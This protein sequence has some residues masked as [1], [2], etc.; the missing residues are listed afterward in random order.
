MIRSL[1]LENW[2]SHYKSDII[3]DSGYNVFVGN[4]GSGKS[5]IIEAIVFALFGTTQSILSKRVSVKDMIMQKPNPMSEAKVVLEF[6]IDS[7]NYKVERILQKE[8]TSTA[9][10]YADNKLIAGPKPSDVNEE[11]EK[12]VGLNIDA[13][14]RANFS[15]QNQIDFFLK[16]PA[17]Q[18]K[19]LFDSIF[20]IQHFDNIA[21]NA[22][23]VANRL[24]AKSEEKEKHTAELQGMLKN[25][26]I[27]ELQKTEK[28]AKELIVREETD[29]EQINKTVEELNKKILELE[30]K[31]KTFEDAENRMRNIEGQI[32]I[33]AKEERI[34]EKDRDVVLQKEK[35]ESKVNK[36]KEIKIEL[37]KLKKL[38]DDKK[39]LLAQKKEKALNFIK[40]IEKNKKFL[41]ETKIDAGLVNQIGNIIKEQEDLLEEIKKLNETYFKY[42]NKADNLKKESKDFDESIKNISELEAKCPV[43]EQ[44]LDAEHK[45]NI[46]NEK[47]ILIAKNQ[48]Q[49]II[50]ECELQ[51][52]RSKIIALEKE[53]KEKEA[54]L[55]KKRELL[56]KQE[57]IE[58]LKSEITDAERYLSTVNHEVH[59]LEKELT[60]NKDVDKA[61]EENE[62]QLQ[63]IKAE[64]DKVAKIEKY[65]SLKENLKILSEIV[66]NLDYN[67]ETH[68][69]VKIKLAESISSQKF[70]KTIIEQNKKIL[71][72][73][74]SNIV[75][76]TQIKDSFEKERKSIVNIHIISD[77]LMI[78][79][80]VAKKTQEEVREK[81]V[82]N[83][84]L[85]FMDLWPK[86]YPYA[87]FEHIKLN[88]VDGDY[89]LEL[90]FDKNYTR[91]L[92]DFIS[93][94]ERSAIAL[95]LRIAM[96]LVMKNKLNLLILDE[97]TH[98][99]DENI[100]LALSDLFNNHLLK[101][102]EQIFVIT[103]DKML[104]NYA[105]NIYVINRNKE[106]DSPSIVEKR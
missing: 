35:I 24:K 2:K 57:Y 86:I 102:T 22:K 68:E 87:D 15:E 104:E 101:F 4:I 56:A 53:G 62:L 16:M 32:E 23:Q 96:S 93:G 37:Q 18:R 33:L 69:S 71:N 50:I 81:I 27:E 49:L 12:I 17:A 85:I 29:F 106:D 51:L 66:Q 11:I 5:S 20:D 91:Q 44:L 40:T 65:L 63:Q 78:F 30:Q 90:Y 92:D 89:K 39:V 46:I 48:E 19:Q 83:I 73:I 36:L 34:S 42:S 60:E 1:C 61:I 45:N 6:E 74:K 9:K 26:N 98:N 94:G 3:F 97:P 59:T 52:T 25:Y 8:K 80:N 41:E 31:R 47:H 70:K 105:K 21:N 79:S 54:E 82:S 99:L 64:F 75:H 88:I 76:Y 95:T 100:V 77:D 14:M 10:L 72:D 13:F 55:I 58:I 103:H 38:L 43:C 28:D 7:V 84:N 67:K